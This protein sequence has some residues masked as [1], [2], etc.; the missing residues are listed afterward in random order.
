MKRFKWIAGLLA[1]AVVPVLAWVGVAQAQQFS[2]T[3]DEDQTVNSS[4]YSTGKEIRVKGTV[5][6]DIF[7]A[8]DNIRIEAK[9]RGD[10]ICAG[11]DVTI[12][13]EVDGDVRVA[14]QFVTMRGKVTGSATVAA[15]NFSLDAGREVG[16]DLTVTGDLLNIKGSV[17]RDMMAAGGNV[18][19]NGP[20]GRN[21]RIDSAK[22]QLKNDARIAGN[23]TYTSDN[24][25]E[26]SSGAVVS[27]KTDHNKP[28]KKGSGY[29]FSLG[30]YLFVLLGLLFIWLVLVYF[31]P[32]FLRKTSDQIRAS[33]LKAFL[34]GL[35][36]S[37]LVPMLS[38]GLIVT[39]VGI[40]LVFFLLFAWLFASLL[41]APIAAYYVGRMI[42]RDANKNPML[43]MLVGG[44]VL[45]TS[46]FFWLMG[47]FFLMLSYWVG[48]GALLLVLK[49]HARPSQPLPE[50][51]Q[52]VEEI[53]VPAP[54]PETPP[55]EK[56]KRT[57]AKKTTSKK[58][59]K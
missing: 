55:A 58:T 22:V 1:L 20:V 36:A 26:I 45:I 41:A 52:T 51:E 33:F 12:G 21:A 40:P 4:L 6:G 44:A 13:G 46:Y 57:T 37:F 34:V 10:V 43:I 49:D 18:T 7:C 25:A 14:G 54:A 53:E 15:M 56:P 5:N 48:L 3:V 50:A 29:S 11:R 16:R 35:I 42:F 23:L 28:E 30:L 59:T 8:G 9:V 24:T 17:G 27:G 39:L 38:L 32:Q 31:F 19:L 47:V 2:N